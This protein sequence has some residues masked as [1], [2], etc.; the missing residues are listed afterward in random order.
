MQYWLMTAVRLWVDSACRH[1]KY[2]CNRA[3]IDRFHNGKS[4]RMGHTQE[5]G[6]NMAQIRPHPALTSQGPRYGIR[7]RPFLWQPSYAIYDSHFLCSLISPPLSL[8]LL[9]VA[10]P[11]AYF[12]F[13]SFSLFCFLVSNSFLFP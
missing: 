4:I 1:G 5:D 8:S 2:S 11:S 3:C 10:S 13:P 6:S 9:I 12:P 7:H